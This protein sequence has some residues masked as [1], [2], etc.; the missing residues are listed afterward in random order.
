MLTKSYPVTFYSD[1]NEGLH[2]L[3]TLEERL[4]NR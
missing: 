3:F 4:E 2:S 1:M